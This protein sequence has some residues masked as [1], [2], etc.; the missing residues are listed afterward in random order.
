MFAIS[1]CLRKPLKIFS[2]EFQDH[3]AQQQWST[4]WVSVQ[5]GDSSRI[6]FQI[7]ICEA[8]VPIEFF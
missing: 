5:P 2:L 1:F 6:C 7:K 4:D 8:I 3:K